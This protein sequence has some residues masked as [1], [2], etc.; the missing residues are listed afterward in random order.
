MAVRRGAKKGELGG[1]LGSLRGKGWQ[2]GLRGYRGSRDVLCVS[3][4]SCVFP[5][6]APYVFLGMGFWRG[7]REGKEGAAVGGPSRDMHT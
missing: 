4:V 7:S 2:K 6:G 1:L 3:C 5:H